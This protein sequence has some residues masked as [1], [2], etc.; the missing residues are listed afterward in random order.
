MKNGSAYIL[1]VMLF[2]IVSKSSA[3]KCL[4]HIEVAESI[5]LYFFRTLLF[6][7]FTLIQ[8][9][10]YCLF[11]FL[12]DFFFYTFVEPAGNSLNRLTWPLVYTNIHTYNIQYTCILTYVGRYY[13]SKKKWPILFSKLL[14]KWFTTSWTHSSNLQIH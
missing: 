12:E 2:R 3:L 9:F 8:N 13:M 11:R 10:L 6:R 1:R 5:V 4:I 14:H 7:V